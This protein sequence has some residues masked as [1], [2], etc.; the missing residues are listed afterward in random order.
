MEKEEE[1]AIVEAINGLFGR[2][3]ELI[4]QERLLTGEIGRIYALFKTLTDQKISMEERLNQIVAAW[5]TM[6]KWIS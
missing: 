4:L 5:G 2:R 1:A 6:G 3:D